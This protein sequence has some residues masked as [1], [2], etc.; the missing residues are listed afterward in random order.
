MKDLVDSL[1]LF[2]TAMVD[3]KSSFLE[4]QENLF[5][6]QKVRLVP[7]LVLLLFQPL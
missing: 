1:K 6:K 7:V 2:I 3:I 5:T 4:R